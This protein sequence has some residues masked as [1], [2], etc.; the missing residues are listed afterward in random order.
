M[1]Y[2]IYL[3]L[4]IPSLLI[5]QSETGYYI[6]WN[7]D[8]T[9]QSVKP[10]IRLS[11]GESRIVNCYFV[12]FDE[13]EKFKSVKYFNSGRPSSNTSYGEHQRIRKYTNYGY[14]DEF[15]NITGESTVNANGVKYYD[16][17]VDNYG[18]WIEKRNIDVNGNLIEEN[19]ISLI[20]VTR[21]FNNRILTEIR[22]NL[23]NDTIPDINDFKIVH[24]TYDCNNYTT[25]RQN[26]DEKGKLV[27]G[28]Y[29]YA[30]VAFQFDQNGM[31]YGEE[32]LDVDEKLI[33]HPSFGFAKIDF[34]D[35]NKFGKNFREYYSDENGYPCSDISMGKIIYNSNMSM[36]EL[37]FYNRIGERSED[38]RGFSKIRFEYDSNGNILK[39]M[40]SNIKDEIIK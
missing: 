27:N 11:E 22:F 30:K 13:K 19:G 3:L 29:G 4:I 9:G 21:D 14:Q 33:S 31:F 36:Q 1:R 23:K 16:F 24:L 40:N 39:R 8:H 2:L 7:N 26:R 28:K 18:Y 34:R 12:E 38:S 15:K 20:K 5:G 35:F 37:S 25:S 17:K 6:N 32:F 10:T